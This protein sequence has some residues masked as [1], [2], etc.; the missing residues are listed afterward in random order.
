MSTFVLVKTVP[1][2]FYLSFL[3]LG[4]VVTSASPCLHDR[5]SAILRGNLRDF[6]YKTRSG[7]IVPSFQQCAAVVSLSWRKSVRSSPFSPLF[8]RCS[9]VVDQLTMAKLHSVILK[10][11]LG[12]PHASG[13]DICNAKS[14]ENEDMCY[15]RPILD[16]L[17][18]FQAEIH[19]RSSG[20]LNPVILTI[21]FN[22][23]FVRKN[24]NSFMFHFSLYHEYNIK[25]YVSLRK[26]LWYLQRVKAL[27]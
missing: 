9:L 12:H 21:L 8:T 14:L 6:Q 5:R 2:L 1:A 11:L 20:L 22:V 18:K 25:I 26:L 27:S 24:K 4:F 10:F 16:I 15:V 23:L 19:P 3:S 13:M 7:F 17:R